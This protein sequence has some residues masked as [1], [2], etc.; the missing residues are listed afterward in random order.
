MKVSIVTV[1]KKTEHCE[2]RTPYYISTKIAL[3]EYIIIDSKQ[4]YECHHQ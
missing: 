1:G 2:N 4:N 3:N